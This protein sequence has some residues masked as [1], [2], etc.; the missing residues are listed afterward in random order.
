MR[1][2]VPEGRTGEDARVRVSV[3]ECAMRQAKRA[4]FHPSGFSCT[5]QAILRACVCVCL[6]VCVCVLCVWL[7]VHERNKGLELVRF[8]RECHSFFHL[9]HAVLRQPMLSIATQLTHIHTH[10]YAHTHTYTHT[11][12]N[13]RNPLS[14]LFPCFPSSSIPSLS[15]SPLSLSS[16][17]LHSTPALTSLLTRRVSCAAQRRSDDADETLKEPLSTSSTASSSSLAAVGRRSAPLRSFSSRRKSAC[18][19][20]AAY[21]AASAI[22]DEKRGSVCVFVCV[23]VCVA[24]KKDEQSGGANARGCP[25]SPL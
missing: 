8:E 7:C 23:C 9:F 21:T 15:S 13:T 3:G 19:A 22:G 24:E 20:D 16:A 14:F 17:L 4:G 12:T 5:A 1:G 25:G 10:T 6:C 11:H 2:C 18:A